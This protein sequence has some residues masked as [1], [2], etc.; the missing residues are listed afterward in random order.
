MLFISILCLKTIQNP[1]HLMTPFR[2]IKTSFVFSL[3]FF[4]I[5]YC[6]IFLN[7]WRELSYSYTIWLTVYRDVKDF[8]VLSYCFSNFPNFFTKLFWYFLDFFVFFFDYSLE[9][10]L[11]FLLDHLCARW[12]EVALSNIRMLLSFTNSISILWYISG[13]HGV[14][15]WKWTVQ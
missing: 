13:E 1:F 6:S 15:L 5:L 14:T 8:L 12:E 10:L 11:T 7:F 3:R 2:K 4:F 9:D